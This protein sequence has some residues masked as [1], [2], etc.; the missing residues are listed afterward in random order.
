MHHVIISSQEPS[1]VAL[2]FLQVNTLPLGGITQLS[3][4]H[5][6]HLGL[7]ASARSSAHLI[8]PGMS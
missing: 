5:L 6:M 7:Q 1:E 8:P 3:H 2:V 4:G